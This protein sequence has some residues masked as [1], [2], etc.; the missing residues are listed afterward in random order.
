M[1]T[2]FNR[3]ILG[4]VAMILI[5]LGL[6]VSVS[7]GDLDSPSAPDATS[8]YTLEDI[9]ERLN[10]GTPGA[11]STFTEPATGPTAGTMHTLNDI[12]GKAPAKDDTNGAGVGNVLSGK[13][14]WGLLPGGGWGFQTGTLATQTPDNTTVSQ[15]AGYYDAFDLSTVDPDLAAENIRKGTAIFGVN[16][17]LAPAA[18]AKRVAK[19]GQTQCWDSNGNLLVSCDGTGQ[20][21]EYQMGIDPAIAPTHGNTGAYNTPAWTGE[22]FTD[23]GDGTVTDN[24]TA[25]VW[26]K[27]STCLGD[28]DWPTALRSCKLLRSGSCGLTDG[29]TAY[30][31]RLPNI[32]E[33]HSLIDPTQSNP[34][35][36]NGHPF[37]GNDLSYVYWSSSTAADSPQFA[38]GVYFWAGSVN[39]YWKSSTY[40]FRCVRGG[41]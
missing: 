25:L 22:R 16:G 11:Q 2:C 27:D 18:F 10:A 15:P 14:F 21:G 23:N 19:T 26:L 7:A 8:S 12:M 28:Q 13:T 36:P 9:Y 39:N 5:L 40:Y 37:I 33:L 32:N 29:S 34:A 4:L 41:Q 35:L 31:W 30:Q 17:A 6:P 24:L 1:N 20:D 3:S 38:W